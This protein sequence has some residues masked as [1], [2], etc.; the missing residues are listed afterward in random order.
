M[1]WAGAGDVARAE[2]ALGAEAELCVAAL[3]AHRPR[4]PAFCLCHG[5]FSP[6]H[7][8]D[9]GRGPGM[10]DWDSFRRGAVELDAGRFLASLS[11]RAGRRGVLAA[12]VAPA[13]ESFL[14]GIAGLVERDQLAWYRA[15]ALVKLSWR[16]SARR[17]KRWRERA[18][19]LLSEARAA[20]EAGG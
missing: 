3:E 15:G 14:A 10:I 1:R 18:R 6:N 16:L 12:N 19:S 20:L 4:S 13:A 2:V 17:P 5:D 7:G 9:L 8:L 11:Q